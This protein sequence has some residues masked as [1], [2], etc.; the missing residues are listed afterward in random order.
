MGAELVGLVTRTKRSFA[1]LNDS[2]AAQNSWTNCAIVLPQRR[3][4]RRFK[5]DGVLGLCKHPATEG[6]YSR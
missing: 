5:T 2:G 1:G 6:M 3:C 4:G